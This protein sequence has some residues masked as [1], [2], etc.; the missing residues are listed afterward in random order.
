MVSHFLRC[1]TVECINIGDS[2]EIDRM[3]G[4]CLPIHDCPE[5]KLSYQRYNIKPVICDPLTRSVC[6]PNEEVSAPHPT[7]K[8]ISAQSKLSGEST[9]ILKP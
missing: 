3:N 9:Y 6:C 7:P 2:C 1:S 8:R 4:K 5:V